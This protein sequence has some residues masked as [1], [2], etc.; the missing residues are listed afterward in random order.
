MRSIS[1]TGWGVDQKTFMMIYRALTKPKTDHGCTVHKSAKCKDLSDLES[2]PN[3]AM[4]IAKGCI[5]SIAKT[6]L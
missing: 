3:E 4:R 5:K 2:V 6:S 1:L